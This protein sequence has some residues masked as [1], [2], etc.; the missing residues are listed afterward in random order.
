MARVMIALSDIHKECA[1]LVKKARASQKVET[2]KDDRAYQ[3][4]IRH[5]AEML[6][7]AIKNI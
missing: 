1:V 7:A 3:Q 5:G 4:G 6:L 2:A